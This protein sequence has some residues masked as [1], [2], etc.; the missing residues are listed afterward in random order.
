MR[1]FILLFSF[2]FGAPIA[3]QSPQSIHMT[4]DTARENTQ[5]VQDKGFYKPWCQEKRGPR[6]Y[7]GHRGERGHRGKK[8]PTGEI[9][10]TGAMGATG[11]SGTIGATG[12]S[13]P[14]VFCQL[15]N[16]IV[17][18]GP[19]F[20]PAIF[21]LSL[22][23]VLGPSSSSS[24]FSLSN[25]TL[26][27]AQGGL[28]HIDLS[29]N[30][31]GGLQLTIPSNT[32]PHWLVGPLALELQINNTVIET[33]SFPPSGDIQS[34]ITQ[35]GDNVLLS[36]TIGY[37]GSRECI[38]SIPPGGG[39]LSLVIPAL[40]SI[41]DQETLFIYWGPYPVVQGADSVRIVLEKLDD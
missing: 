21:P 14:Q 27:I 26:F 7:R 24:D 39:N 41:S 36:R 20:Y 3:A 17:N 29:T 12:T 9:G 1:F 38:I 6:G 32:S 8:G 22:Q 23:T 5:Y 16:S 4:D 37:S 15:V 30:F 19:G 13:A 40:P 35:S 33:F 18:V 28:Y 11:S 31:L 25:N 34:V 2:S 10:A